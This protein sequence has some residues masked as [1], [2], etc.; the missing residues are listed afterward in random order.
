MPI[1]FLT[2][3]APALYEFFAAAYGSGF[4][5]REYRDYS[6]YITP[7][8]LGGDTVKF[9]GFVT[10]NADKSIFALWDTLPDKERQ[11]FSPDPLLKVHSGGWALSEYCPEKGTRYHD[12][13]NLDFGH[14]DDRLDLIVPTHVLVTHLVLLK[15]NE[16]VKGVVP[17]RFWEIERFP[18]RERFTGLKSPLIKA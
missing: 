12:S 18:W 4:E 5:V 13:A 2:E 14:F 10:L 1:K 8:V 16:L 6:L 3:L 17:Q 15:A 7:I 11:C 9:Q